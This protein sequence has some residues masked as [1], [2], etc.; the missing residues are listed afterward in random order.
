MRGLG[1]GGGGGLCGG[2]H[3]LVKPSL[4]LLRFVNVI[5]TVTSVRSCSPRKAG[6]AKTVPTCPTCPLWPTCP[7]CPVC[8]TCERVQHQSTRAD[9]QHANQRPKQAKFTPRVCCKE[10]PG[11][12]ICL[13][14][15]LA[16]CLCCYGEG[17]SC[18]Q[19]VFVLS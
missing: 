5:D 14:F 16:V 13:S 17:K 1:V 15:S 10:I 2:G 4:L 12:G 8:P 3:S 7:T 18:G 19:F 11:F 9:C 6:G